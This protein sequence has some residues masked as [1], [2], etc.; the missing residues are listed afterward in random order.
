MLELSN[1]EIYR[2]QLFILL[3][4]EQYCNKLCHKNLQQSCV[5]PVEKPS[6]LSESFV[7]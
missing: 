4:Y 1:F 6:K 5:P 2:D 3:V 7:I